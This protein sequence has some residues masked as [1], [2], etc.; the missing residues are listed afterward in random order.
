MSWYLASEDKVLGQFAS[1][2]GI[3]DL[4]R[5]A[6]K[7]PAV[8]DLLDEGVTNNIASCVAELT[9]LAKKARKDVADT[10][11]GLAAMMKDQSSV[12]IT[13]G[14]RRSDHE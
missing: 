1:A 7:C 9:K 11:T 4:R 5:S 8:M 10:A 13:D 2:R 6:A 3:I 12:A 14:S